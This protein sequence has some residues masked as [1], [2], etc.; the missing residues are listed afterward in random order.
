M[1]LF[2]LD[3]N[4]AKCARDHCDRHIVKMPLET[5][6]MLV[7][8]F[9][10]WN[11]VT[12][13]AEKRAASLD[14]KFL[15]RVFK[16]LP[17]TKPDGTPDPWGI[18][19]LHHPCT[20][21]VRT[22]DRNFLWA[23]ELGEELSKEYSRRYKK[24]HAVAPILEWIRAQEIPAPKSSRKTPFPQAMPDDC[25]VPG[26]AVAAYR[27]FYHLHKAKFAVWKYSP[28]PEWFKL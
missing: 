11:G 20:I 18:G 7:S 21:W 14:K 23:L 6:Q 15:K 3:K 19:H 10:V 9:W 5:T 1:N 4:P 16:K 24:V 28:T 12:T 2:I 8:A 17:R 26:D 13:L 25:K 22:N 27:K